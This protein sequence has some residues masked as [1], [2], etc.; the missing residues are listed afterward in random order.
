MNGKLGTSGDKQPQLRPMT[1]RIP[2]S[3]A[4]YLDG[5]ALITLYDR[6]VL[7]MRVKELAAELTD[8]QSG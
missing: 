4:K 6:F 1:R 3:G 8:F 5:D 7:A 2:A